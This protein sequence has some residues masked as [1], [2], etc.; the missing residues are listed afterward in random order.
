MLS[1]AVILLVVLLVVAAIV[2]GGFAFTVFY[3][4]LLIYIISL[5]WTRQSAKNLTCERKFEKRAF[6]G[7]EIPVSLQIRNHGWLPIPWLYVYESLPFE[8]SGGSFV[9]RLISRDLPRNSWEADKTRST[10]SS[11]SPARTRLGT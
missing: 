11:N 5:V 1:E 3:L 8:L 10:I 2:K 7:E 9:K 4:F 6:W